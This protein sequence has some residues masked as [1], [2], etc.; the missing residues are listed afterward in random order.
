MKNNN[1]AYLQKGTEM[2]HNRKWEDEG[3]A[4]HKNF[5]FAI[6]NCTG[7]LKLTRMWRR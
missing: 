5:Y 7:D 6:L 1:K 3:A 4:K 2:K